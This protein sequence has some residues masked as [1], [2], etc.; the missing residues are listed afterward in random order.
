VH[1]KDFR[2]SVGTIGGFVPLGDG[3]ADWPAVMAALRDVGYDGWVTSETDPVRGLPDG[4]VADL[5][6]R[7][8]ALIA[9]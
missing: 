9:L 2:R 8:D 6:R 3:D 4:G 5:A 1:L 7:M